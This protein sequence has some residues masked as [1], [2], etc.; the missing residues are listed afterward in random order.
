MP[1][2]ANAS[3]LHCVANIVIIEIISY[4]I[5][6]KGLTEYSPGATALGIEVTYF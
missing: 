1:S 5:K 4:E 6:P 3:P 2:I